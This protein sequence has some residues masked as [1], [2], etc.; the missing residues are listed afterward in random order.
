[1]DHVSN[2]FVKE[3][4]TTVNIMQNISQVL[5]TT[6]A[7]KKIVIH[8]IDELRA[9]SAQ[10]TVLDLDITMPWVNEDEMR[11]TSELMRQMTINSVTWDFKNYHGVTEAAFAKLCD[12][13]SNHHNM[14]A[15]CLDFNGNKDVTKLPGINKLSE[16]LAKLKLLNTLRLDFRF[17]NKLDDASVTKIFESLSTLVN[18]NT[19]TLDFRWCDQISDAGLEKLSKA[20]VNLKSLT[21]LRLNLYKLFKLTDNSMTKLASALLQLKTLASLSLDFDGNK[22]ITDASLT[23]LGDALTYLKNLASINLDLRNCQKLT[24]DAS[25]RLQETVGLKGKVY[26]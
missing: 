15:L 3:R 2:L 18:L 11:T 4:P 19:L 10:K 13:V 8:N 22:E 21:S 5:K 14:T 24:N 20:L 9:A 1:V 16:T 12:A 25:R 26:F 23:Q 17:C 7:T 6:I